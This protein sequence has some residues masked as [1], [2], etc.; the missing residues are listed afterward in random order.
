MPPGEP[1]AI[2]MTGIGAGKAL[3]TSLS[4][5]LAPPHPPALRPHLLSSLQPV[6]ISLWAE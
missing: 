1:L 6:S 5:Y 2:Q 4:A 3:L